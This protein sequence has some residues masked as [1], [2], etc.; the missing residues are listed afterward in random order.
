MGLEILYPYLGNTMFTDALLT[1][2]RSR[3]RVVD[4]AHL[5]TEVLEELVTRFR[6]VLR[7]EGG[8]EL[9]QDPRQQ[10]D[11]AITA[12]FRSWTGERAR[13]NAVVSTA[14]SAS[15][16]PAGARCRGEVPAR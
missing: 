14:S 4:D 10:L 8:A 13:T 2:A 12:V 7:E 6:G 11:D 16:V 15:L 1:D 9:P 3:C 5:P